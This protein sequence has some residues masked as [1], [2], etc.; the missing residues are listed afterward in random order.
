MD[1]QDEN[2]YKR[3][4]TVTNERAEQLK[5]TVLNAV[6]TGFVSHGSEIIKSYENLR[7]AHM[8]SDLEFKQFLANLDHNS[9]KFREMVEFTKSSLSSRNET[10]KNL[11]KVLLSRDISSLDQ[12]EIQAQ[13]T[14]MRMISVEYNAYFAELDRLL[15]L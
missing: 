3:S 15:S 6:S 10:I 4:L 13:N 14:I 11:Q 7:A 2:N 1:Y 12:G 8:Q 9:E 5:Q